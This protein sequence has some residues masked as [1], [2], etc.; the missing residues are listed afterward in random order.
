M[1]YKTLNDREARLADEQARTDAFGL[2]PIS[3]FKYLRESRLLNLTQLS[4]YSKVNDRALARLED[5]L[6]SSPLPAVV[7]YWVAR[8][9]N[10]LDLVNQY[11]EFQNATRFRYQLY[12]GDTLT[13]ESASEEH[14]FRQLRSKRPS[15]AT[16]E[17]LPVGLIE[18]A[19][20]M[21]VP[22]DTIQFFEKKFRT[23]QSVP[24]GIVHALIN[25]GYP[26]SEVTEFSMNYQVWRKDQLTS[27]Q[28]KVS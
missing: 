26:V 25:M 22:L 14:P 21:C 18:C 28:L 20:A 15:L 4:A 19:K 10:E 12:F 8:G 16:S 11:E 17:P 23:Q 1:H 5:G 3:P 7:H 27:N 9:E 13:V 6:Y 2:P 24:K